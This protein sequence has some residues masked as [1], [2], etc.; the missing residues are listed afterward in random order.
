MHALNQW[1]S[2]SIF[3]HSDS[4]GDDV[5][6]VMRI[7]DVCMYDVR[8]CIGVHQPVN[9]PTS[10][11]LQHNTHRLNGKAD[12]DNRSFMPSRCCSCVSVYNKCAVEEMG[13]AIDNRP[14]R[15]QHEPK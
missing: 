1:Q 12:D 2:F 6:Y 11:V 7:D 13:V 3:T 15:N 8:V 10:I 4:I 9:Q 5:V 14:I